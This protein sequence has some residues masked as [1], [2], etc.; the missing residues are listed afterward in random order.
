MNINVCCH[1]SSLLSRHLIVRRL[2]HHSRNTEQKQW[3]E[4]QVRY[5]MMCEAAL[6]DHTAAGSHDHWRLACLSL[7][8]P[9]PILP[10]R[11][12]R[13]VVAGRCFYREVRSRSQQR[14]RFGMS[15]F[16]QIIPDVFFFLNMIAIKKK[17]KHY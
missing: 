8:L 5:L 10:A 12:R 6:T 14:S 15:F 9:P 4:S 11:L 13:A 17:K 1:H 7:L 16:F 3:Y 2:V